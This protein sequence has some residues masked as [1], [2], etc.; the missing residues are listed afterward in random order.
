MAINVFRFDYTMQKNSEDW[1]AF[2]A[3]YSH[4]E[5]QRYLIKTVGQVRINSSGSECRLD[6]I[7]DEIRDSILKGSGHGKDTTAK[8]KKKK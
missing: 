4:E 3:A 7:S 8:G 1:T 6:A 2:V 5:A